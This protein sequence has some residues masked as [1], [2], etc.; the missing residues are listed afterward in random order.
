MN[1]LKAAALQ[2]DKS[3]D[4]LNYWK[5]EKATLKGLLTPRAD[6]MIFKASS[7]VKHNA[8]F[9]AE[10]IDQIIPTEFLYMNFPIY[11]P[12]TEEKILEYQDQLRFVQNESLEDMA[13]LD[14]AKKENWPADQIQ[15]IE[16]D[17][18]NL[19]IAIDQIQTKI[20]ILQSQLEK[21]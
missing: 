15:A 13:K 9:L 18:A 19:Q 21:S 4:L 12:T 14:K 11:I 7:M 20:K 10:N 16:M 8:D 1:P 17:L 2:L 5:Q 3:V 6:W